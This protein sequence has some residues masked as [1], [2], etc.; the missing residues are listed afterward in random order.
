MKQ[1]AVQASKT[2]YK[3]PWLIESTYLVVS[4][5]T[6][7][8]MPKTDKLVALPE[9]GLFMLINHH[10]AS[11]GKDGA[12]VKKGLR[13]MNTLRSQPAINPSKI[14]E[15]AKPGGKIHDHTHSSAVN[16]LTN[17]ER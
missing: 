7:A 5:T 11:G 8:N 9:A 12:A 15:A 16:P 6:E 17:N 13:L 1:I 3:I 2:K 4:M 14:N 10:P